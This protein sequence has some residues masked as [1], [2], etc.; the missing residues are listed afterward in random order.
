MM[1]IIVNL[2]AIAGVLWISLLVIGLALVSKNKDHDWN[3][4]DE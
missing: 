3:D 1:A 2:L 4:L